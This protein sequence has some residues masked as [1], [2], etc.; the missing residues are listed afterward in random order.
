MFLNAQSS[1]GI[2][3]GSAMYCDSVNSGFISL[4]AFNGQVLH[5]ESSTDKGQT[6]I[7]LPNTT[8]TQSYNKLMRT[9]SYRA[10]VKDGSFLQ[11]TSSVSTITVYV[12]GNAGKLNGGGSFCSDAGNGSLTL[13]SPSGNV[14]Y[15][16]LSIANSPAWKTIN[17][18]ST[19]L[20]YSSLT[21]NTHYRVVVATVPGCPDDTTNT[22]T[23]NI[24]PRTIAG[25]ILKGDSLCY[26]SPGDTLRLT[27]YAGEILG[28]FSSKD[29]GI[30]WLALP[31]TTAFITYS[32]VTQNSLY[33]ATV[34]NGICNT[35]TT[36]PVVLALY[37]TNPA[38]AGE[39]I[40]ITRNDKINLQGNG[41]G[42]PQW[43]DPEYLTDAF[44]FN[45]VANPMNTTL[46]ILTL[47][48]THGCITKDSVTVN[49]IVPV[50]TAITP[51]G[52]GVNDYFEIDKI[53]QYE[54]NSLLIFNR[55]GM[56]VYKSEPYKNEWNGKSQN[57]HDLPDELYYYI[58]NPGNGEK[59]I[60]N[61]IL[62]KR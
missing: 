7:N 62:I 59:V 20:S 1:G 8:S 10:I 38:N 2:T 34:K 37:N 22:I 28:W 50:P 3:T 42:S 39:D 5:W 21:E 35:E 33:K 12:P 24:Q 56:Q 14:L 47:K 18:T 40:T 29:N 52:D 11:D 49:V 45:P 54:Q 31:D 58:F 55:W 48:D 9:T 32:S 6:W 44:S 17:N 19:T 26:G 41:N 15:W 4:N 27:E 51:N 16:Q 30:N 36:T 46:Y 61:Y 13:S 57:G 23:F 43:S 25:T 60:T 53:S